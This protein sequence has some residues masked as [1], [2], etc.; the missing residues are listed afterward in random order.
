MFLISC[1]VEELLALMRS[2]AS[3]LRTCLPSTICWQRKIHLLLHA[4]VWAVLHTL[5]FPLWRRAPQFMTPCPCLPRRR[6]T[7]R[8]HSASSSRCVH[9]VQ[10]QGVDGCASFPFASHA[11][12]PWACSPCSRRIPS[13][14][15]TATTT[16][17]SPTIP[18]NHPS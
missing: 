12:S 4:K 2:I 15:S 11:T 8:C 10:Q 7:F 17:R 13:P 1:V 3:S 6:I 16:L 5:L 18:R 14:S 9:A